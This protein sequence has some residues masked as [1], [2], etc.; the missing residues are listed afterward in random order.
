MFITDV[1]EMQH[2]GIWCIGS[3]SVQLEEKLGVPSAV[4][5]DCPDIKSR[6]QNCLL[7]SQGTCVVRI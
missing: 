6:F 7:R 3:D 4:G 5:E 2:V 1:K